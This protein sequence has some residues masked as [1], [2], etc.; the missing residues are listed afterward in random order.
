MDSEA[1]VVSVGQIEGTCNKGELVC[2][3]SYGDYSIMHV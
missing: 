1:S 3:V 2:G